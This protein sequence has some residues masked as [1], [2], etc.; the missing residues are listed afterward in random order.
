MFCLVLRRWPGNFSKTTYY[1]NLKAEKSNT[2]TLE[3]EC[4]KAYG[5]AGEE[6][7]SDI[8]FSHF[9]SFILWF[10]KYTVAIWEK[11]K[12][13]LFN[14]CLKDRSLHRKETVET[15]CVSCNRRNILQGYSILQTLQKLTQKVVRE[16][17]VQNIDF[18]IIIVMAKFASPSLRQIQLLKEGQVLQRGAKQDWGLELM[19]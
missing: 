5:K 7:M 17:A 16:Q 13:C 14:N 6:F 4:G 9:I 18:N 12:I 10:A 15:M 2:S 11:Q 19:G 1:N 8:C 3:N